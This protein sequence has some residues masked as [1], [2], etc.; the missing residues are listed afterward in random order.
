MLVLVML[1][2]FVQ[3]LC[4]TKHTFY[5]IGAYNHCLKQQALGKARWV[6]MID[7]DEFIVPA[8]GIDSFKKALKKYSRPGLRSSVGSLQIYWKVF[9]TSHVWD[10]APSE[11]LIEKLCL[12]AQTDHGWNRRQVKSLYRPEAVDICLIHYAKKLYKNYKT[13]KLSAKEFSIHHYWTGP[14]KR[15]QEKRIGLKEAEFA[16]QFNCVED[17]TIYQYLPQLKAARSM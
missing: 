15:F 5:Q 12:R 11:L 1:V 10:I 7:I 17:K 16:D 9:G 2:M 13:K 3:V 8:N 14:E 6:G 4:Q